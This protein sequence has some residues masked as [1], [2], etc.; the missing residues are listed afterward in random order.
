[1]PRLAFVLYPLIEFVH[2]DVHEKLG[3]EVPQW[4]SYAGR[5]MKAADDTLYEPEDALVGNMSPQYVV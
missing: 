5:G 1:M 2:V 4:Q 3:G